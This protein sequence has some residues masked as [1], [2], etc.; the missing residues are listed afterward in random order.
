MYSPRVLISWQNIDQ[1]LII[2]IRSKQWTS[3]SKTIAN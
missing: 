1:N 2:N 3:V